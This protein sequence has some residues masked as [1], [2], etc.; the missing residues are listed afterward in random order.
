MQSPTFPF[1]PPFSP[2]GGMGRRC[3]VILQPAGE[4]TLLPLLSFFLSFLVFGPKEWDAQSNFHLHQAGSHALL[5]FS[6]SLQHRKS[7]SDLLLVGL[8]T[9]GNTAYA[10]SLFLFF[11]FSFPYT[12]DVIGIGLGWPPPL[13]YAA[14]VK[15]LFGLIPLLFFFFVRDRHDRVLRSGTTLNQSRSDIA[16]GL[17]P[18]FFFLSSFFPLGGLPV[19]SVILPC[20]WFALQTVYSRIRVGVKFY[21]SFFFPGKFAAC[22]C[23]QTFLTAAPF[24]S[25][26]K[27]SGGTLPSPLFFPFFSLPPLHSDRKV[28]SKKRLRHTMRETSGHKRNIPLFLSPSSRG[29]RANHRHGKSTE[30]TLGPPPFANNAEA[31]ARGDAPQSF[32]FLSFFF[33]LFFLVGPET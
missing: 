8:R 32:F 24:L 9:T 18:P 1:P 2:Q 6:P 17:L 12:H 16:L 22:V 10:C 26:C 28:S 30:V 13:D 11:L 4:K 20:L 21:P 5:P 3:G 7:M 14:H 19:T 33:P 27:R 15:M 23:H 29:I 25:E 31:C